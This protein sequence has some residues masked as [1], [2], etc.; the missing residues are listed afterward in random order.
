MSD[1][2]SKAFDEEVFKKRALDKKAYEEERDAVLRSLD[3]RKSDDLMEKHGLPRSPP[4]IGD[5]WLSAMHKARLQLD[6]FTEAEK[7]VSRT[8]L[9]QNGRIGEP[10]SGCG[11][12]I[13]QIHCH[14][15]GYGTDP[16]SVQ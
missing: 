9:V 6:S 12:D 7:A 8:W 14:V 3:R 10:C 5:A 15:C 4:G 13:P 11:S 1:K 16:K 2:K